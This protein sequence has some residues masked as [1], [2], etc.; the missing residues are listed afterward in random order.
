MKY[1]NCTSFFDNVFTH[2]IVDLI[3]IDLVIAAGTGLGIALLVS[4]GTG[5]RRQGFQVL[6][7]QLIDPFSKPSRK[8]LPMEFGHSLVSF[9]PQSK[10]GSNDEAKLTAYLSEKLYGPTLPLHLEL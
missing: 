2:H 7:F 6:D 9:A 8:V 4:I 3:I 10:P 5:S 1:G